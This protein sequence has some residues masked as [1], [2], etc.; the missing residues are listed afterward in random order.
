MSRLWLRLVALVVPACR[1]REWLDEWRGELAH[2][3]APSVSRLRGAAAHAWWMR[4][5]EWSFAMTDLRY[6]LRV[7][8]RQPVFTAV[9]VAT[10]ALGVGAATGMFA[11]VQGVLRKPLAY[12]EPDRLVWMWGAFNRN[13]SASIS[14]P[15]FL[16]YRERNDAFVSL[17]AMMNAPSDATVLGIDGPERRQ[18]AII[19]PITC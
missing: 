3:P 1:R 9:I 10:L 14:P 7:L 11:V 19:W 12:A 18:G 2:A 13:D 17:G 16:D 4:R 6:A 8:G 5:L 15:D